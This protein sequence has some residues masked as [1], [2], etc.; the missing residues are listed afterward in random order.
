MR[1]GK[2]YKPCEVKFGNGLKIGEAFYYRGEYDSKEELY[3]KIRYIEYDECHCD[4]VRYNAV[5][6]E[7][8]SLTEPAEALNKVFKFSG[9]HNPD[10]A[11]TFDNAVEDANYGVISELKAA[12]VGYNNTGLTQIGN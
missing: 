2:E 3:M 8:G 7:D 5:N 10:F 4:M 12:V 6:L 11:W 1:I 9:R